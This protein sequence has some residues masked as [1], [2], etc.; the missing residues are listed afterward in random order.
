MI[1]ETFNLEGDSL[2]HV[3]LPRQTPEDSERV[4]KEISDRITDMMYPSLTG[5]MELQQ[6][7]K[8]AHECKTME[9]LEKMKYDL[10]PG[11]FFKNMIDAL[12]KEP[13]L[14]DLERTYLLVHLSER[15]IFSSKQ[16]ADSIMRERAKRILAEKPKIIV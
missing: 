14:N 10:I 4:F 13:H 16:Y 5:H 7:P 2:V 11:D 12:N 3:I 9:E 1:G 15:I 6:I 8:R